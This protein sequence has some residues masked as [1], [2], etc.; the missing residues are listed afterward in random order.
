[1]ASKTKKTPK[2]TLLKDQKNTYKC[3]C[4]GKESTNMDKTFFHNTY[5]ALFKSNQGTFHLCRECINDYYNALKAE[6]AN[7]KDAIRMICQTFDVYYSDKVAE[8][9]L[10]SGNNVIA[11][12]FNRIG[13]KPND[14]KTYLN[15]VR[16]EQEQ[17]I[18]EHKEVEDDRVEKL[19]A[20]I[21]ELNKKIEEYEDDKRSLNEEEQSLDAIDKSIIKFWG[22]GYTA[23]EYMQLEDNYNAWI[24]VAGS[25]NEVDKRSE[26]YIIQACKILIDINRARNDRDYSAISSLTKLYSNILK[27]CGLNSELDDN[28]I[29]NNGLGVLIQ[30]W[31]K[32][33]PVPED[34]NENVIVKYIRTW[35]VGALSK[36]YGLKNDFTEDYENEVKKYTVEAPDVDES[37]DFDEILRID[38]D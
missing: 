8:M 20:V 24:L 11:T 37:D 30:N 29:Q 23:S 4:C 9:A 6:T 7:D 27:E 5:S 3:L 12:Y 1:M 16:E 18:L 32:T 2:G 10:K 19:Q 14:G 35:F 34:E 36:T 33:K 21:D 22:K 31:E 26:S 38:G 17:F 15:N 28:G 25:G 13:L